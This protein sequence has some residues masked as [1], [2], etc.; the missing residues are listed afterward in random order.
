MDPTRIRP[1]ALGIIWR[2]DELLVCKF[3]DS[4][5]GDIF[6]RPL[7]GCIE[8]GEHGHEAVR[9]EFREELNV[10]LVEIR[11]LVTME[12]IFTYQGKQGHEIVLLYEA[13]LSDPSFYERKAI[14]VNEGG[15]VLTAYW[16]PWHKFLAGGPPLYPNGLPELLANQKTTR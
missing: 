2:G 11:Y 16:M 15:Q 12:N 6:Y 4:V 1:L 3:Y 13:T 14:E 7:G 10:E 8:F 9:R 5:K